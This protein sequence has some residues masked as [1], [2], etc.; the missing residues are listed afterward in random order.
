[1][2][3]M[4]LSIGDSPGRQGQVEGKDS[5]GPSQGDTCS[6]L[7]LRFHGDY[8]THLPLCVTDGF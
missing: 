8:S 1:M 6:K 7:S 4:P 5:P 2:R 3:C